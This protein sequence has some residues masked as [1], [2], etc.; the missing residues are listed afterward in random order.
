M[1]LSATRPTATVLGGAQRLF[2]EE[3]ENANY[4]NNQDHN[5]NNGDILSYQMGQLKLDN[6]NTS[7]KQPQTPEK[8]FNP[9]ATIINTPNGINSSSS[10]TTT[11]STT[12]PKRL[13]LDDFEI[14]RKLGAGKFGNVYVAREKKTKYIVAIKVLHIKQLTK[15]HVEHQL[16][17]EIEI[18]SQLRHP[19]VLR[20]YAYFF[21]KVRIYLVLEYAPR[22]ELFKELQKFGRYPEKKAAQYVEQLTNALTYCHSKNVIHR[23][24][25]PENLLIGYNGEIKMADFGWSVHAPNSR[26]ETLCGTLDYLPPEMVDRRPHTKSVDNWALGILTYEFLVGSPP[27]E[28]QTKGATYHR[29]LEV[30][31]YFPPHV[32]ADARDFISRLLRK[33]PEERMSLT[34]V[35]K[36]PWMVRCKSMPPLV[37]PIPQSMPTTTTTSATTTASAI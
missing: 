6:N 4:Q 20:L 13:S 32:A 33:K 19:N 3:V 35:L 30:D 8:L 22:G 28:A 12:T 9:T 23:D 26:R 21:D 29:I 24:I 31:L 14:G 34:D 1:I 2:R 7:N 16:R 37:A 17:R 27:F 25:K 15:S 11:T 18:Q 10:T 36:H 5:S